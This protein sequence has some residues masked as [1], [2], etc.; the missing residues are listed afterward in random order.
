MKDLNGKVA[1]VT[2][3]GS[4]LGLSIAQRLAR[5]GVRLVLAVRSADAGERVVAEIR[6]SGGEA[7][8]AKCD[9][10]NA[11]EVE[12]AVAMAIRAYGRLDVLVNNAGSIDPI[13]AIAEAEPSQWRR[14]IEINLIGTYHG[15][16]YALPPMLSQG[17][18]VL[19]CLSS[20]AARKPFEGWS[21]YCAAKA[22]VS[23]LVHAVHGEYGARG[24]RAM[25]Y[26]PGAVDTAMQVKIRASGLNPASQVPREKLLTPVRAARGAVWLCSAA[27][28]NWGGR[29]VHI[30]D[31][32]FT[33]AAGTYIDATD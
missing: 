5:H 33:Q 14:A 13:A 30:R 17:E 27:A 18:G 23:M 4:G 31:E 11:G 28:R 25:S 26:M 2:G 22:G 9:V 15:I 3:A 24:I 12:Q 32:D 16:R 29:E 8:V 7:L 1:L 6:S 19:I 20:N 10:S 21:A